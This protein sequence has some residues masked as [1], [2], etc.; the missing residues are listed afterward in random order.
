LWPKYAEPVLQ[1]RLRSFDTA[2]LQR[3]FNVHAKDVSDYFYH[4][5]VHSDQVPQQ[6]ESN[7]KAN[8]GSTCGG[9]NRSTAVFSRVS[10]R[11]SRVSMMPLQQKVDLPYHC[12]LLLLACF[13]GSHNDLEQD[14]VMFGTGSRKSGKGWRAKKKKGLKKHGGATKNGSG[15]VTQVLKGPK[16]FK[17][18]RLIWLYR[19]MCTALDVTGVDTGRNAGGSTLTSLNEGV[20]SQI[21]TLIQLGLLLRETREGQLNGIKYKCVAPKEYAERV[22]HELQLTLDRYLMSD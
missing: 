22:A 20:Y 8:S 13:L 12:K 6:N 10:A 19:A 21:P 4:H 3:A 7:D 2:E 11:T 9:A 1:K 14:R 5:D 18:E 16:S 17:L 15:S